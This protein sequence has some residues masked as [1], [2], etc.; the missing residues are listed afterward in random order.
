MGKFWLFTL[1]LSINGAD[2]RRLYICVVLVLVVTCIFAFALLSAISRAPDDELE[3]YV[4]IL[5]SR[6]VPGMLEQDVETV[7]KGRPGTKYQPARFASTLEL[8]RA[9]NNQHECI[10]WPVGR[11]WI[12]V[13]F[14]RRRRA[15]GKKLELVSILAYSKEIDPVNLPES[16]RS[17]FPRRAGPLEPTSAERNDLNRDEVYFPLAKIESVLRYG[18]Q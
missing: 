2:V 7:L 15:V 16:L 3:K 17:S 4:G 14:D 6:I 10:V 9:G 8:D 5:Y 11:Y 18:D 12:L 1:D 13:Y